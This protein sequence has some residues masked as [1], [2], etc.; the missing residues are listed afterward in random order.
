MSGKGAGRMGTYSFRT[1]NNKTYIGKS[2]DTN[3]RISEHVQS[4]KLNKSDLDTLKIQPYELGKGGLHTVETTKIRTADVLTSGN[5]A[6]KQN[7]PLS[8]K[9]QQMLQK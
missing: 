4:G 1:A 5:L 2:I 3:R 8:R 6:N 7:A 9:V